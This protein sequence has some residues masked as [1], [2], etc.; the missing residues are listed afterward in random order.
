MAGQAWNRTISTLPD[1]HLLQTS[2]WAELKS[3]YGWRPHYLVWTRMGDE[4][5]LIV[6]QSGD[7]YISTPAAA[8]LVLERKVLPGISVL[9]V[10][11]GPLLSDWADLSLVTRILD[12]LK[13][14]GKERGAIQIKID[15]DVII[16]KGIPETEGATQDQIGR[17]VQGELKQTGWSFSPDQIQFRNTFWLDLRP[18]ENQLLDTMK[19][20]TRY[21]IRLSGRKGIQIRLGDQSDL[22]DL[23]E[24]YAD[25]SVR[26]GFTIR[27]RE[28]YLS[29][30]E[31][32]MDPGRKT[33]TDPM[34]QPIIAEYENTPVAG[35]VF[36]QFG[37]RAWYIHGMSLADHSEK[38]PTYLI[39]WE[40]IRWAQSIGCRIY[41]MWGAPDQFDES[42]SM[43]GVFRFKNGFGGEVIRTLGAWDFPI[44]PM[45]YNLYTRLL[46]VLLNR[47]RTIGDRQTASVATQR[48]S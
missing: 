46:P 13:V 36:F 39:Q 24:M 45:L 11:K 17:D 10:P 29:L 28:Y 33:E 1:P 38:M 9:Y 26:G 32:F 47:M 4:I 43:W 3:K 12:D 5:D 37:K 27:G 42:D 19:S 15:P 8:A 31:I 30:W 18:G 22:D 2:Q 23:Y 16:G 41:D 25:T 40:G 7:L 48:S 44:K 14:F 21:N 34:A 6:S 35:A 20:K